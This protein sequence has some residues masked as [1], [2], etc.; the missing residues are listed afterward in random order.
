MRR[1]TS[2]HDSKFDAAIAECVNR[3]FYMNDFLKSVGTGE[4]SVSST[5]QLIELL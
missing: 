4:Q 5:K 3:S 2:D 1:K